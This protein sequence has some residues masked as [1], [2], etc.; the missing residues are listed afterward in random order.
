[1]L[2]NDNYEIDLFLYELNEYL[3]INRLNKKKN[4]NKYNS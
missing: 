2:K 3:E 4:K 1:M